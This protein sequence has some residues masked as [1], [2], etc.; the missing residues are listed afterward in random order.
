MFIFNFEF[1]KSSFEII[2]ENWKFWLEIFYIN[3][4]FYLGVNGKLAFNYLTKLSSFICFCFVLCC[5]KKFI[6]KLIYC[7]RKMVCGCDG[8]D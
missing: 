7:Y 6:F 1:G 8:V 4:S 5:V 2:F 3:F